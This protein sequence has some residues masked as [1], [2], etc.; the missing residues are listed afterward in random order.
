MIKQVVPIPVA[1]KPNFINRRIRVVIAPGQIL[2]YDGNKVI[3]G[4]IEVVLDGHGYR[5]HCAL[6]RYV[7]FQVASFD[8]IQLAG[9]SN[10]EKC[11][12]FMKVLDPEWNEGDK[13]VTVLHVYRLPN[14]DKKRKK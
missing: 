6:A 14:K 3:P 7:T 13:K 5:A 8:E 11:E 10:R 12:A 9:F 1:Y 2:D 4:E